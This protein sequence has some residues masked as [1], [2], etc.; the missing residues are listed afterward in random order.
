MIL[1]FKWFISAIAIFAATYFIPGISVLNFYTALIASFLLGILNI[2]IRPILYLLTLPINLITF[3]LFSIVLNAL[4][5]WF[6]SAIVK[7]LQ[8]E[9]FIP[10]LLGSIF[11]FAVM[12]IA[13]KVLNSE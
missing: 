1:I 10:A 9:G 7:G 8:I 4:I 13:D 6:L 3:G 11:V 2:T 12:F 5:F